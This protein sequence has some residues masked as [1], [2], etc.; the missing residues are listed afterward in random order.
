MLFIS[1]PA[2]HAVPCHNVGLFSLFISFSSLGN[3]FLA[4]IQSESSVGGYN[5]LKTACQKNKEVQ[6]KENAQFVL[7]GANIANPWLLR[8]RNILSAT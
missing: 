3:L 7:I 5:K 2:V 4:S 8:I 1:V 6:E